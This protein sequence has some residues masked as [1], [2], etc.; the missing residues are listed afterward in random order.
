MFKGSE[1]GKGYHYEIGVIMPIAAV[2]FLA[3]CG[4]FLGTFLQFMG[5]R[6][7][8]FAQSRTATVTVAFKHRQVA[9]CII[10]VLLTGQL[11]RCGDVESNPGPSTKQSTLPSV[12][13]KTRSNSTSQH[14]PSVLEQRGQSPTA[15]RGQDTEPTIGDVMRLLTTMDKKWAEMDKKMDNLQ[16]VMEEKL[17]RVQSD[18]NEIKKENQELKQKVGRLEETMEKLEEKVDDLEGRSRRNNLLFHGIPPPRDRQETWGDCEEAIK[19][20]LKD[21]MGIQD[22]EDIKVE[23]AHR[24]RG[25]K[26]PQPIIACFSSFKDKERI[27]AGR[28]QLREQRSEVYVSEDFSPRV[29][30][31]RRSLQPFL[32]QAKEE[33]KRA[34]LR[35]D[36]LVIDGKAFSL[37]TTAGILMERRAR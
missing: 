32:K 23:R 13:V 3:K 17:D 8:Q 4:Q 29:R 7:R 10:L 33:G 27:L 24:L 2:Q 1:S 5:R 20:V 14:E 31:K 21:K 16:T 22:A 11:L 36:M 26:S 9:A 30:E 12:G 25:G 35:F 15:S 6:V 18:C 37:D 34:F 19:G 28:R